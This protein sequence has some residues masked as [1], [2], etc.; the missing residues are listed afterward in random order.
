MREVE[1]SMMS[2]QQKNSAYFVGASPA[3]LSRARN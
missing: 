2:V 1:D 3:P